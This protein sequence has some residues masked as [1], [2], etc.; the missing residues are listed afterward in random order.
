MHPRDRSLAS[1]W[2]PFLLSVWVVAA[3][4][5][6]APPPAD[7]VKFAG[8]SAAEA[9]R[10]A[11]LP[12]GFRMHV[13]AAEPDVRQPIAFCL[14]HRGRVW[15]AEGLTYPRRAPEGQGRDRILVLED[16]D[17]D[18]RFDKRTVFME[19]VNLI[20]GLEVGFGGVW[21]GAA[22]YLMFVPVADWDNPRPAGEPRILLDGWNYTADTHETLNTFTWGPDGW[23][24]G[25]HG[26]FCPSHVGK[27]G[28]AEEVRQWVDAAAWRY[29]P[30]RHVFEV[31]TEGGSNPWGIDFD[32][33]G[34]LWSEMCV[35]PHLWHMIQ[36]ARIERQGGLHYAI[37]A[38]EAGRNARHRDARSRKPVFPHVYEDIKFH[39]DHLHWLGN[40]GPHAAN[41]RSDAAGGGHAHAG[42][43][44]YLG[45][46]WPAE[47]RNQ[48]FIGNIHGQ[49]LNVDI[50]ERR[51]SGFVGRHGADFLNFNDTWSQTLNQ[52]YDQDGSVFIIDWY[53]KNQCHHNREDGHDRANGRVYKVVYR[54]QKVSR[55][56]VAARSDAELV[57]LVTSK[58]EFLSRHAR[59]VLQERAAAAAARQESTAD[60][61]AELAA[62]AKLRAAAAGMPA[63]EALREVA[64]TGT[65][66]AARLRAMWGLHVTGAVTP[67][68]YGRWVRDP[69]EWVRAWT[70]RLFFEN[71][72][73]VFSGDN[74]V[75]SLAESAMQALGRLAAADPSP[76]VRLHIA[77][78]LQRVPVERR[79][80]VVSEL[81]KHAEDDAD[82]NLPLMYWFAVEGCV[83]TEPV[84]ALEWAKTAA[85]PRLRQFTARRFAAAAL[86]NPA[87]AGNGSRAQLDTLIRVLAE[88][89]EAAIRLD[90]L[91]GLAAALR[92]GQSVP[93]PSGWDAVEAALVAVADVE[94]RALAQAVGLA[95][96]SSKA[97]EGL[98]ATA[99]DTGVEAGARRRAL[100][101]LLA[102]RDPALV[103]FLAARVND[104][105]LGAVAIRALAAYDD[106]ATP[107]A[108]LKA[109]GSLGDREKR[110]ALATLASR[111]TFAEPLMVAIAEGRMP[112]SVLT[113]DLLRQLGKLKSA[114]VNDRLKQVYGTMRE[115]AP[116]KQAEI[117]RHKR[118]YYA[119]GSQPGDAARG[120]VVYEKA[121]AQCHTLFDSGGKV[122]PDLTGSNRQDLD[123]ILQNILDPNAVI[124]NEYRASTVET[125]D[126]RSLT[127]IVKNQDDTGLVL[128]TQ[129]ETLNLRRADIQSVQQSELSMMPEG[130]LTPLAEQEIR[131]LI[132]YLG[133][134]GQ[135]AFPPGYKP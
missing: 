34:Q 133:R 104:P 44:V 48:L 86:E 28:A 5:A 88:T 114:A 60:L 113:A 4:A 116:D 53:D 100:E 58:N 117:E 66:T 1:V 39:G 90:I 73:L 17:G 33:H 59:R 15:V 54:D 57:A 24:Y 13:F 77:S 95:F 92:P 121:C 2:S 110:D 65:D 35:I 8:L 40:Q 129:N 135:A 75:T 111:A 51:G 102:F 30:V 91:R 43:M 83:A 112:R 132:Y 67:E 123:Y 76:L 131:D 21:I 72:A 25:C 103:P 50:L 115:S 108:L 122:G 124:P 12:E 80:P 38:A 120:R 125:K 96:G 16:T 61:P 41:A 78:A 31:F 119:G 10:E 105:A 29:H 3:Q 97:R 37:D 32:E 107:V 42:L 27:P 18:H 130:L 20:S 68:D 126:G 109:Y 63:L 81:L 93:M 46:G 85:I 106:P 62:F 14:D 87:P 134:P 9:A 98:K 74:R 47:Y 64:N 23:L 45:A 118:M 79:W 56:D 128:A 84:R 101:T 26:V 22:P 89:S 55:L 69:D 71:H 49:R 70:I 127:G 52:L 11:T 36:G 99:Q 7:I 82:H 19:G 94:T 6:E